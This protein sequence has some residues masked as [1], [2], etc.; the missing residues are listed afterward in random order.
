MGFQFDVIFI[1]SFMNDVTYVRDVEVCVK[2]MICYIPG[3]ICYGSEN[4]GLGSQH[5]D[6]VGLA[7]ASPQFYSEAPYTFDYR[8]VAEEFIFYR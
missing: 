2:R 7:G 1:D 3:C 5:N 8:F 4:F 6:C